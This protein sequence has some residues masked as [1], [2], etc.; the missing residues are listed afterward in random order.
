MGE[1][2]GSLERRKLIG[3]ISGLT[4]FVLILFLPAPENMPQKAWYTAAV[5][6]LMATFWITEAI[7]IPATAL[8]PLVLFPLLGIG[9][10]E[11]AAKPYANPLIFLF[12]GGFM[13]AL[14]MQ[15]WNLHRRLALNIIKRIGMHPKSIVAGFMIA[16]AF[17][18]MWVSN[19]ATTMMMMPIG[20]SI[21]E[22][23]YSEDNKKH[24]HQ[25]SLVLMLGIAYA[26]NI[27]GI[28]TLIGTPPNA[29]LAGFVKESY[30][31][32]I[33]FARW[34]MIGGPMVLVGL[35]VGYLV[36]TRIAFPL[37]LSSLDGGEQFI[38]DDELETLG[39]MV[40]PE[41]VVGI[42]FIGVAILWITRPLINSIIPE[43]SDANIAMLGAV[44]LFLIPVNLSQ[45]KFVMNWETAKK[46]PW[47]VLLLF[48]GGLSLA[49]AINN[50]GLAT[51]IGENLS[52]FQFFP[53][54]LVIFIITLT[55]SL[56]TELTS[57][58]ATAATFLPIM[59]SLAIGL[60]ENPLLLIIPTA[61]ATSCA[62]M[63]PVGTP[64]NAIVYGSGH[65]E[66]PEM[67][68]GGGLIKVVFVFLATIVAYLLITKVFQV[69]FG[70]L[71]EWL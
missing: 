11:N 58:T 31:Y 70:V 15:R 39:D 18:S 34:L 21:I 23:A 64:P 30:D 37:E 25:F 56:L 14:A 68:K 4:L 19:T 8:L 17:L 26:A 43:L 44:V 69:S 51:W 50:S 7:P 12:M 35:P 63:L 53:L 47:G 27:G 36:L 41:K 57:N 59:A 32:Q 28:G 45:G 67:V 49:S 24:L 9:S 40:Y 71:P 20:L 55:V 66:I 38:D 1:K 46:C 5:A 42:V 62:F 29:L 54:L 13:I 48:G 6:F 16:T 10:M 2:Q 65:I 52:I 22:L 3:L 60:G 33:S 61:L